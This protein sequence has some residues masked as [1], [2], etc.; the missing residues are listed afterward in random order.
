[1]RKK[2]A[3]LETANRNGRDC[4]CVKGSGLRSSVRLSLKASLSCMLC[5]GKICPA[6]AV[7]HSKNP[8][9]SAKVEQ[10]LQESA[11][12]YCA[13]VGYDVAGG[14]LIFIVLITQLGVGGWNVKVLHNH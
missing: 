11:C 8:W 9:S 10:R 4:V 13:Y 3:A 14:W 6:V 5:Y 12:P 1:M 2:T 7:A